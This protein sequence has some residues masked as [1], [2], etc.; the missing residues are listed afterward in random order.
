[1]HRILLDR[2][3]R[4]RVPDDHSI[5]A[6]APLSVVASGVIPP[7][8]TDHGEVTF[9]S[10]DGKV[11]KR[12]ALKDDPNIQS[13]YTFSPDERRIAIGKM[14]AAHLNSSEKSE[15]G[16][17]P[18]RHTVY[19]ESGRAMYTTTQG[20]DDR[21]H[22]ANS[23]A[24]V[25]N[26]IHTGEITLVD[27]RTGANV[28]GF[29]LMGA[30]GSGAPRVAIS[31]S[32]QRVIIG[33]ATTTVD[34]SPGLALFRKD[35]K[36]YYRRAKAEAWVAVFDGRAKELWRTK[37]PGAA[38]VKNV[39]VSDDGSVA[40]AHGTLSRSSPLR[41]PDNPVGNIGYLLDS[42]GRVML[43]SS[44]WGLGAFGAEFSGEE[45]GFVLG[46]GELLRLLR[47]DGQL[48]PIFRDAFTKSF[49][50]SPMF[51]M[52]SLDQAVRPCLAAFLGLKRG[53]MLLALVDRS[54]QLQF[55][56]NIGGR[57][58]GGDDDSEE[59][60][61]EKE[62]EPG[63]PK[64]DGRTLRGQFGVTVSPDAS[65][66]SVRL[67]REIRVYR[68]LPRGRRGRDKRGREGDR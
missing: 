42:T 40:F 13:F 50:T 31:G 62:R 51:G 29:Q 38:G 68:V 54:G 41:R 44:E 10:P 9:L 33:A 4:A 23:G 66:V 5:I 60:K 64:D 15:G 67:A 27:P 56:R 24:M 63:E 49:G 17:W 8:T 32:G 45:G 12:I 35:P 14:F 52:D 58:K 3:P 47:L 55:L 28:S 61:Q 18:L 11:I 43:D 20:S 25:L 7:F 48:R 53:R 36:E 19:D 57:I 6:G 26:N 16:E 22:L 1:V 37:L 30:Y 21:V 46:V 2:N 34:G 39:A 65:H 59:L